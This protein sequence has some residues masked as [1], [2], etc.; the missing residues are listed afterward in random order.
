MPGER[1]TRGEVCISILKPPGRDLFGEAPEDTRW[2]ASLSIEAVLL[3]VQ[4]LLI[5]PNPDSPANTDAATLWRNN[6]AG[7]ME[8]ARRNVANSLGLHGAPPRAFAEEVATLSEQEYKALIDC[9]PGSPRN[10][11]SGA[12]SAASGG[13]GGGGE[14]GA[15]GTGRSTGAAAAAAIAGVRRRDGVP[16]G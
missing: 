9:E 8:R 13:G 1:H 10:A 4:S 11:A 12:A 3:S 15:G 16:H 7:F 14:R 6:R 2:R 5:D